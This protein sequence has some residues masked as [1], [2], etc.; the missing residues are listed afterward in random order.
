MSDTRIGE[1]NPWTCL[2]ATVVLFLLGL[3]LF[4]SFR[5]ERVPKASGTDGVS[6]QVQTESDPQDR[7]KALEQRI[8]NLE[9]QTVSTQGKG[10]QKREKPKAAR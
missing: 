2:F 5:F 8:E 6:I 4:K 7:M 10:D 9:A 1:L 3:W